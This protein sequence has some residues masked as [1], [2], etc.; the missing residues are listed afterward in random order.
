MKLSSYPLPDESRWTNW[1]KFPAPEKIRDIRGPAGPGVYQVKNEK[2]G[3]LIL[4]GIG[5]EC[6]KRMQSLMP[7]PWGTGTRNASDKRQYIY[8]NY[9][10]LVYRFI[11]TDT[12][13]EAADIERAIKAQNNHLFN[14]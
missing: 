14:R 10:D 8:D 2:T 4:F 1:I 13:K 3:E 7:A 9:K 11:K 5:G 6:Q 12:R